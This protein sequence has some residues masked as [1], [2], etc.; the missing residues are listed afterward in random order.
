MG[1]LWPQFQPSY[2]SEREDLHSLLDGARKA[3]VNAFDQGAGQVTLNQK[4][5]PVAVISHYHPESAKRV[6]ID[7]T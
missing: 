2:L 6:T 5:E 3:I 7:C 4:G 1:N